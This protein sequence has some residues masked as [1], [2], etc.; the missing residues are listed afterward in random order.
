MA[1]R[2]VKKV[3]ATRPLRTGRAVHLDLSEED[4]ERLY[5]QAKKRGLNE[6]SYV[7]MVVLERFEKDQEGSER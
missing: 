3:Q 5:E 2:A 1:G 4:H 6:A 7:R